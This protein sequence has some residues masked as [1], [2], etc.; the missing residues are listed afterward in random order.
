MTLK[1]N[2]IMEGDK[3]DQAFKALQHLI[4]G[5]N[6]EPGTEL[7]PEA[8]MARQIG[9]SKFCMREALRVAKCHGLI[10]IGRGHRTRVADLSSVAVAEVLKVSLRRTG[11]NEL[12]QLVA[13]RQA[14]EG[15]IARF[16]ALNAESAHLDLMHQT[17]IAVEKD[18][19]KKNPDLC[20]DKDIE[21]HAILVK[22]SGNY[23]FEV[24]LSP[25]ADLLRKSR[26]E[27]IK[28]HGADPIIN[29]HKLI[30]SA[31]LKKN[32]D[33]AEQAMQQHLIMAE[34]DIKA[35]EKAHNT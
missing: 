30:L 2:P 6:L 3:V 34:E 22:A 24:M 25:L 27:T 31:L 18:Q 29:D 35:I 7:P 20:V 12:L 13:A 5:K 11:N 10:D 19:G 17:I 9:V 14:L 21:F 28:I 4:L 23:V 33:E 32:P 8:E 1:L 16:A 15:Q 26:Y